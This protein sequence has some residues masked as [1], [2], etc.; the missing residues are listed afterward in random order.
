MPAGTVRG[1]PF[2]NTV[3]WTWTCETSLGLN[4]HWM[5]SM[6]L[7]GLALDTGDARRGAWGIGTSSGPGAPGYGAGCS[8]PRDES[9]ASGSD[10]PEEEAQSAAATAATRRSAG[11]RRTRPQL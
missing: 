2:T 1:L 4:S 5:P 10:V 6:V 9:G 3:R 8:R 7:P 11:L